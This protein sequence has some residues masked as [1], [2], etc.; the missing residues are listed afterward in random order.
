M[1]LVFNHFEAKLCLKLLIKGNETDRNRGNWFIMKKQ[2]RLIIVIHIFIYK[3]KRVFTRRTQGHLIPHR[4]HFP[5]LLYIISFFLFV[6]FFFDI[7]N[8]VFTVRK[9]NHTKLESAIKPVLRNQHRHHSMS[10]KKKL[11]FWKNDD[12]MAV[13]VTCH[14]FPFLAPPF[15]PRLIPE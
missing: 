10:K 14:G 11:L 5:T 12:I 1:W 2:L 3:Y 4:R 7:T 13:S 8:F 9:D 6:N 15:L